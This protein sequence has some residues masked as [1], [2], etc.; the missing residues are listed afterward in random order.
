MTLYISI[1]WYVEH[2]SCCE[3]V[4][5]ASNTRSTP[6]QPVLTTNITSTLF[7]NLPLSG[8]RLLLTFVSIVGLLLYSVGLLLGNVDTSAPIL[9]STVLL[10]DSSQLDSTACSYT[11][12]L[13]TV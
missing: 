2:I 5:I 12:K 7:E 10:A 13:L 8:Q 4:T 11:Q 3:Q 6:M 1:R 9:T